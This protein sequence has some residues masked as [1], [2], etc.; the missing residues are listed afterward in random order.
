MW[1]LFLA[2]TI[3][4]A[5]ELYLLIQIGAWVGP[6]LTVLIILLTGS[7]GAWLAKREG[8]GV[9][10][11]LEQESKQGF[12]SGNK[13]IEGLM[14]LIGGVLLITPGVLTDVA[15]FVLIAP[16]TRTLLAPMVKA[17]VM[18]RFNVTASAESQT[19]YGEAAPPAPEP[20]SPQLGHFDHPEL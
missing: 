16:P 20:K 7:V 2:F 5:L 6:G 12:P 4:P 9:L 13:L 17:A 18:K 11:A 14:V 19:V 8:L 1:K 3:I 15:G 10:R